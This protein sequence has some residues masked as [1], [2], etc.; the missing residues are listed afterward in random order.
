M[1]QQ[2]SGKVFDI[3]HFSIS[4]GPGIRTTVFLKGCP[5]RCE[6]CH[7]PESLTGNTQIMYHKHKCVKCGMCISACSKNCHKITGN[8]HLFDSTDCIGC[9]KC[10]DACHFQAMETVGK[11]MSV[12][13]VMDAVEEDMFFYESSG[14]G[15]T[16]SGGEP[17]Y[18]PDFS[19]ALAKCAQEKNIHVCLE[20]SGFCK[21]E[22]LLEIHPFV[23]LFLFDY[24]ATGESH[25]K[26]T[27]VDNALILENLFKLDSCRAQIILRCPIIPN[28]N[29]NDKHINGIIDIA[30][31]LTNLV[32]IDLEPYHNIGE[33]KKQGLGILGGIENKTPPSKEVMQQLAEKIQSETQVRTVVM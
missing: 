33:G 29:L 11:T 32:E 14:G 19:I 15:M 26:F 9:H 1:N 23:D 28:K 25:K 12:S 6:W 20:T 16:L 13:E 3:Q 27:G 2:I 17:M 22:K 10:V 30:N 21:T 24:K 18:Q 5:L 8:E 4:D 7:N 31:R